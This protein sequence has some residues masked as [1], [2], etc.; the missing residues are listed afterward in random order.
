M[1]DTRNI[2]PHGVHSLAIQK[3]HLLSNSSCSVKTHKYKQ[4]VNRH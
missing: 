2:T 4:N 1:G 3:L